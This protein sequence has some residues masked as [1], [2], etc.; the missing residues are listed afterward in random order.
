MASRSTRID[1]TDLVD[2]IEQV[3]VRLGFENGASLV[4]DPEKYDAITNRHIVRQAF[5]TIG[6]YAVFGFSSLSPS[7]QKL[8]TPIVYFCLAK[9][10]AEADQLHRLTWSQGVTPIM[11]IATP[12]GL[13]VRKSLGPPTA[14]PTTL[15]WDKL[16]QDR[17]VP[18][19]LVS[20]NAVALRSSVVWNDY[21]IDRKCRVDHTL[22]AAITALNEAV[23]S[24]FSDEKCDVTLINSVIGRF[25][26]FYV[27]LDRGIIDAK[28][29]ERL[30]D[31]AGNPKCGKIA[32]FLR[33]ADTKGP[34]DEHWPAHEIWTLFD[35]IDDV[36]NGAIFPISSAKKR[37]FP[38]EALHLVRRAIRHG[39]IVS[40]S[41]RQLGF[42]DVSFATL[43]T[44]TIS[45]IYELFLTMETPGERS[46]DG[47]YY[48]PPFLV[49]YVLDEVDRHSPFASGSRVIDPAAGSGVFL[50]GAFRRIVERNI[51]KDKWS[52]ADFRKARLLLEK[53]IF[54]IER[55]PQ[56]ANVAR[57]S[58]YLT[59]LDYVGP[60]SIDKLCKYVKGE[61]V[62]PALT[63]NIIDSDVFDQALLRT[64]GKRKFSHVVGNPPWGTFGDR[65]DRKNDRRTA[66]RQKE[67]QKAQTFAIKFFEGLDP[68]EY[69][70]SNK[71]L[72]ELFVWK[73]ERDLLADGGMLG[74]L[75]ST[76]SY[77]ARTATK[78]PNALAAKLRVTGLANFS[79]FRYRLFAGARSP[80]IAIFGRKSPPNIFD[81]VWVYSPLLTSQPIGEQGHLWSIIP[82]ELDVSHYRLRELVRNE[83]D[84]FSALMLR[85]I[86]RRYADY[87]RAWTNKTEK[88]FSAFLDTQS[89]SFSRGGSPQQTGLPQALLLGANDYKSRLG[90]DG[91]DL[92][93]YP[94][95]KIASARIN[96]AFRKIFSGNIVFIPRHMNEVF[97]VERPIAFGSTFNAIFSNA[98]QVSQ[99][100]RSDGLKGVAGF[101]NSQVAH[102]L[103]ALFGK[104]W[105]L[106][107]A[108]LEKNDLGA[109]P[110]PFDSLSDGDLC[111]FTHLEDR[112]ITRVFA[113]RIG[114]DSTF[115]SVVDEYASFRSGFED[116][117]I[118]SAGLS[119]PGANFIT[120]YRKSLLAALS[121]TFGAKAVLSEEFIAP[122]AGSSFG[123][124]EVLVR[125]Q[126]DAPLSKT[127]KKAVGQPSVPKLGFVPISD[128]SFDPDKSLIRI[129]KP[130]TRVAWTIEQAYADAQGVADKILRSGADA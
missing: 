53:S 72:S 19:E 3:I 48:T 41:S 75:I 101:L 129:V 87:F 68:Q 78:F 117:Q 38:A 91:L 107:H 126:C 92:T 89:L 86:D 1:S 120:E 79:H 2:K 96:V 20:L 128:L 83:E 63:N 51:H 12:A 81:P 103:Y 37:G 76:R 88:P 45:A 69:P 5:D 116:S 43:R 105:L 95:E 21:V 100:V 82:S 127:S 66:S 23:A 106:D 97:F 55:N 71:R 85:P 111:S 8:F 73:I 104:T 30:Q 123:R 59:L 17:E 29:I 115:C 113:K 65:N 122:V 80:T 6:V 94:H 34:S 112:N 102:Y 36:L 31:G 130:W 108:R 10:D 4:R 42:I 52:A 49:D 16:A 60:L 74:I 57:F 56:A 61:K 77:V 14:R 93:S 64:L 98:D 35:A 118:P 28:W 15:P 18:V 26:Y 62:F 70:V 11:L 99:A 46:D 7:H 44:E 119:S 58:L 47:A 40:T 22:L 33:D 9:S 24:Q 110:F 54:G 125:R 109:I 50:V 39:D 27:L 90:L 124:I 114:L 121:R 32:K 84:W 67:R 13:Q 25:L